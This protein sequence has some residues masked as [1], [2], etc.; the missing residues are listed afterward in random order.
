MRLYRDKGGNGAVIHN[1][2]LHIRNVVVRAAAEA[3]L[4]AQSRPP[5]GRGDF[6]RGGPDSGGESG[7][8][9]DEKQENKQGQR[10]QDSEKS[11]HSCLAGTASGTGTDTDAAKL[12]VPGMSLT[13]WNSSEDR[14][15]PWALKPRSSD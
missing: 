12:S 6:Q 14:G 3:V 10:C 8:R 5:V 15:G 7:K 9:G 1:F 4:P 2:A 11:A 13:A